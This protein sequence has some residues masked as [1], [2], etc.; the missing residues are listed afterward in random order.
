MPGTIMRTRVEQEVHT[1]AYVDESA[2]SSGGTTQPDL[3]SGLFY[4]HATDDKAAQSYVNILDLKPFKLQT[5]RKSPYSSKDTPIPALLTPTVMALTL[6]NLLA[7]DPY[8]APGVESDATAMRQVASEAVFIMYRKMQ[9]MLKATQ[10]HTMESKEIRNKF[11]VEL[12]MAIQAAARAGDK[13]NLVRLPEKLVAPYTPAPPSMLHL[14]IPVPTSNASSSFQFDPR[15]QWRMLGHKAAPFVSVPLFENLVSLCQMYRDPTRTIPLT[16]RI[17]IGGGDELLHQV[18]CAWVSLRH[19]RPEVLE[20]LAVQFGLLPFGSTRNHLAAFIARHD[21]W[22]NRHIFLPS[23]AQPFMVPWVRAESSGGDNEATSG[24][25]SATS[26]S[27]S[28]AAASAGMLSPS[29]AAAAA[30]VE[31]EGVEVTPVGS[32]LRKS[33][34]SYARESSLT[35]NPFLYQL[36]GYLTADSEGLKPDLKAKQPPIPGPDHLIPFIQRAELG[37]LPAAA[38]YKKTKRLGVSVSPED[39]VQGNHPSARGFEYST[40]IELMVSFTRMDLA[41]RIVEMVHE[42]PATYQQLLLTTVPRNTDPTF[43]P[44]PTAPYMELFGRFHKSDKTGKQA[45]MA[46]KSILMADPRQHVVELEVTA[47]NPNQTFGIMIDNQYF[48]PYYKV[49]LLPCFEP[50]PT[51]PAAN[52]AATPSSPNNATPPVIQGPPKRMT[53]PIQH[54]FPMDI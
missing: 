35:I 51:T 12:R 45:N 3:C 10:E 42:D 16:L 6:L 39:I 37:I 33:F 28:A 41:G 53:F 26:T 8:T 29:S 27:G 48:G 11:L 2:S 54:F 23:R 21:A 7:S 9:E 40:P 32:F 38:E 46:R 5:A 18:V 47:A 43:P 20:G 19:T 44:L 52:A 25:A 50:Q 1:T 49:K 31:E 24:A 13:Q 14:S 30:S 22:Y 34:E 36:E 4:I 17:M 15:E